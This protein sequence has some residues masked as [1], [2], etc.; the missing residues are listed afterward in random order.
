[1]CEKRKKSFEGQHI[2]P[3]SFLIPLLSRK[4]FSISSRVEIFFQQSPSPL[5]NQYPVGQCPALADSL[6]NCLL[7][8]L[9]FRIQQLNYE[10]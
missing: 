3:H 5:P 1:M 10:I 9:M 6:A 4:R 7:K 8:V 2:S